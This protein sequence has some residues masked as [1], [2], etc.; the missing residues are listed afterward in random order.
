MVSL[1]AFVWGFAGGVVACVALRA[2][3]R[4]EARRL[5]QRRAQ[6]FASLVNRMSPARGYPTTPAPTASKV[7]T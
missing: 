3:E 1:L 2:W 6:R 5:E 7:S 4:A